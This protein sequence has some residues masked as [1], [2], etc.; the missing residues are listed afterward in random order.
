MQSRHQ[1]PLARDHT[2]E[3][4]EGEQEL[5]K[6][7]NT[8]NLQFVRQHTTVV[9]D[10]ILQG[11]SVSF[12]PGGGGDREGLGGGGGGGCGNKGG[13]GGGGGGDGDGAVMYT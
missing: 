12:A 9:L 10:L 2:S 11:P 8:I 1:N 4:N 6:S 13:G 3:L 7:K 5:N